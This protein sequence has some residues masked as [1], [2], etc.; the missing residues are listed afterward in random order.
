MFVSSN[1][2]IDESMLES[3]AKYK[4]LLEGVPDL[5]WE[6]DENENFTFCSESYEHILGYK[7]EEL[8]GKSAYSIM[9]KED[10]Q[11]AKEE[12]DD[13]KLKR[14]A[15][16]NVVKHNLS[17][18]SEPKH[19][20]S[21]GVPLIDTDGKFIGYM[22]IDRDI[23]ESVQAQEELELQAWG[24]NKANEG[25]KF[26]YSEIETSYDKLRN[27]SSQLM[28]AE[29]MSTVGTLASGVAHELNNPLMGV[30]GFTQ[31]CIKH[32]SSDDKRYDVLKDIE[33]EAYRCIRIV[34]N[35]LT[36]SHMG[37]EGIE[38]RREA[39][40]ADILERV[41]KLLSY[42][43]EKERV[44]F[45]KHYTK[46]SP[47]AWVQVNAIQQVFL[48]IIINALDALENSDKK[49]IHIYIKHDGEATQVTVADTGSGISPNILERIFEPFFT[50]KTVGK[51]TGLGLFLSSS[52]VKENNGKLNCES[53]VGKGTKFIIQLSK[54][55]KKRIES[56]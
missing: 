43:I 47:D 2:K 21:S 24:L 6:F 30:L 34:E 36:F 11:K 14:R 37:K 38:E 20:L 56:G 22:G 18:K 16:T 41:L 12:F 54:N 51:G 45:I 25:I 32:T 44:T 1:K 17:I 55:K 15:F 31:Y 4:K 23:T 9:P 28:Q 40:C 27:Q 50:T 8:L 3:D 26:L 29:K 52:I 48:N 5:V 10:V 7:P 19:L 49:E 39:S 46:S 42:R 53:E 33:Q 35:L 13:I